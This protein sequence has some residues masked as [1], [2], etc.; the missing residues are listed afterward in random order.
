MLDDGQCLY[1]ANLGITAKG[2]RNTLLREVSKW[3]KQ[4]M[5]WDT[6][7]E[8][9]K[10]REPT[11]DE[12]QWSNAQRIALSCKIWK[13]RIVVHHQGFSNYEFGDEGQQ[14]HVLYSGCNGSTTGTHDDALIPHTRSG[15]K[16]GTTNKQHKKVHQKH[17]KATNKPNKKTRPNG[18]NWTAKIN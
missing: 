18:T 10:F 8:L 1:H 4:L 12:S 16:R 9:N 7:E 11:S 2:V 17:Q 15:S 14:H 6:G 3:W 5:P 13:A